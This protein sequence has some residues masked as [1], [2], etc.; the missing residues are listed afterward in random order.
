METKILGR[1]KHG[2]GGRKKKN[3]EGYNIKYTPCEGALQGLLSA[4]VASEYI[5]KALLFYQT[6]H[7]E[8]I[9]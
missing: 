4:P 1:G 3:A 5:D 9:N 7:E 2:K 8:K 6:Q